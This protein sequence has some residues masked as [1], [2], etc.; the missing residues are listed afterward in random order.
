MVRGLR[1]LWPLDERLPQSNALTY[2]RY[3]LGARPRLVVS[4]LL[5]AGRHHRHSWG[6]SL[7]V[8]PHGY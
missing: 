2:R 3:Q 1:W 6:L 7:W 4:R 8:A 5:S